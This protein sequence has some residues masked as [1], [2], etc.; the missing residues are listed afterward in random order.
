MR[1]PFILILVVFINNISAQ[2]PDRRAFL[3]LQD[4][5]T[6]DLFV[7]PNEKIF[8]VTGS[9]NIY[10]TSNI[11]SYWHTPYYYSGPRHK[12]YGHPQVLMQGAA[13]NSDTALVVGYLSYDSST[14]VENGYYRTIDGGQ[15]WA[16]EKYDG[17]DWIYDIYALPEGKAWMG[18]S[19]GK[20]YYS[21]DFGTTW[22]N[23]HSPYDNS[24]RMGCIFMSDSMNGISAASGN[25]IYTTNDN[26][27]SYRKVATPFDEK[28]YKPASEHYYDHSINKI[29]LWGNFIAVS[30]EGDIFYTDRDKIEW[31]T[32]PIGITRFHTD[33]FTTSLYAV[34]EDSSVVKFT[35]PQQYFLLNQNKIAGYAKDIKATNESCYILDNNGN[36]Y[37]VNTKEFKKLEPYTFDKS[38]DNV[39]IVRKGK[40]K[41]W[42][43]S[44]KHLYLADTADDKKWYRESV[45]DYSVVEIFPVN[46]EEA[47]LIDKQNHNYLYSLRT[48]KSA[49]YTPQ[50]PL[51]DFLRYPIE[52]L[53]IVSGI[54]SCFGDLNK[55]TL[56][57][58]SPGNGMLVPSKLVMKHEPKAKSTF[59]SKIRIGELT[60]ILSLIDKK[61]GYVS[62][63]AEFAIKDADVE[64]YKKNIRGADCDPAYSDRVGFAKPYSKDRCQFMMEVPSKID[65]ISTNLLQ[66]ILSYHSGGYVTIWEQFDLILINA[67]NDTL[68]IE[69]STNTWNLPWL[70]TYR[71]NRFNC[72][73]VMLSK[74]I[75]DHI[76]NQF[77]LKDVF[78]NSRLIQR[79]ASYLYA[80]K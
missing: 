77:V 11:D 7:S 19:S 43:T 44:D 31:K 50:T 32:F 78:D 53:N 76:P 54:H 71:S 66:K 36:V 2:V 29:A 72:N 35:T 38:I 25:A 15:D 45:L 75:N 8:L 63:I 37:K 60:Q 4:E 40:N 10:Y 68:L 16:L 14:S 28:K 52:Q 49:P 51:A 33:V 12:K 13:F 41:T 47:I 9:G 61:P 80:N 39:K 48:H 65:T 55:D 56:M 69:G 27:N 21:R 3:N 23:L 62:P 5:P 58:T 34:T 1:I 74:F 59:N 24:S 73:N 64:N 46:E 20:I 42:G 6:K 22:T 67:N 70:V 26:W 18:G 30:Q 57:Y 17:N 79:I